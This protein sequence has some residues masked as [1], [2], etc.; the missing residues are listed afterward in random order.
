MDRSIQIPGA[1]VE[2]L[3]DFFSENREKVHYRLSGN[4]MAPILKNGD[5]LLIEHG[6][7]DI[8]LGDIVI[9]HTPEKDYARRIVKIED[10]ERG[11][12]TLKSDRDVIVKLSVPKE[13]IVGKVLELHGKDRHFRFD[14][15]FWK[16]MN[17]IIASYSYAFWKSSCS[18]TAFWKGIRHLFYLKRRLFPF[19]FRFSHLV[20]KGILFIQSLKKSF[21]KIASQNH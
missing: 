8:R 20:L 16:G 4:C 11:L 3:L 19:G 12:Y 14:T 6:N 7:N 9:Y 13:K 1:Y 10:Y 2:T 15:Y 21:R 18:D 5:S 17:S